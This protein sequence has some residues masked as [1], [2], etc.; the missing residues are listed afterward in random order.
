[1]IP[2]DVGPM[3]A[4]LPPNKGLVAD[5]GVGPM[6]QQDAAGAHGHEMHPQKFVR[7]VGCHDSTTGK[8]EIPH[9]PQYRSAA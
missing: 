3:P 2:S 9:R 5:C 1:M 8:A 7:L 6:P 4:E